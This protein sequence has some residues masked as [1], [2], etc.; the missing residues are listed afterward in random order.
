MVP[1][2]PPAAHLYRRWIARYVPVAALLLLASGLVGFVLGSQVPASW[3]EAPGT[4]GQ[5]AFTPPELTTVSLA[6]HNL[7]ALFVMF[8]GAVSLGTATVLSLVLNGL[9]IG[10]V[11]AIALKQ[12]SPV[13]VAALIVPHGLV[14]IPALLLVAA[15]G[16][17]FGWLS[18]QYLRG[19]TDA[20]VTTRD[21]REAGWLL[22]LAVVLIVVAAFVEANLTLEIAD[23][24]TDAD[25]SGLAANSAVV[26]LA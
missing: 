9:V 2:P 21:L 19:R 23:R 18:I 6:V 22:A 4:A 15:V 24:F 11:I 14:E 13:V 17:R 26:S 5:S 20:F 8:L 16:L 3:L 12:V 10:A 1:R 25:L 7:G